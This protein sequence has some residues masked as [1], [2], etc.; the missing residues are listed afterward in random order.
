MSRDRDDRRRINRRDFAMWH[1]ATDDYERALVGSFWIGHA[2][3]CSEQFTERGDCIAAEFVE[4]HEPG[5]HDELHRILVEPR[6]SRVS[7]VV[8]EPQEVGR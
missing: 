4:T 8:V 3:G 2:D 1:D 7:L 6:Q 5:S